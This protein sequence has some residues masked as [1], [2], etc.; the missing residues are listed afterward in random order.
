MIITKIERQKRHRHKVNIYLDDEFALG[1]HDDVLLKFGLRKGDTIDQQTLE[2]IQLS[3]EFN[4]AKEK[5]LKLIGYRAR[6]EKEIRIKLREQQYHPGTITNVIE[7]LKKLGL[8]DDKKFARAFVN[9]TIMRKPAGK[10]K[11]SYQLRLKGIDKAT[12]NDVLRET[13]RNTD[14]EELALEAAKKLLLHFRSSKK[15]TK[16]DKLQQRIVGYLSRQGFG[17]ATINA[18]LRKLFKDESS[19]NS[20]EE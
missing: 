9:D 18:V 10:T 3:E 5:A 16:S 11:L 17:W 7:H 1:I 8:I 6:S 13:Y 2:T 20:G 15:T 12:I 19:I 14:E 4:L